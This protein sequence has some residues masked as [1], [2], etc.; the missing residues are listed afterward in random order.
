MTADAAREAGTEAKNGTEGT[1]PRPRGPESFSLAGRTA[2]VTGG[3]GG[4]GQVLVLELAAA[5]AD[6]V[7]LE[8]PR[9]PGL[10]ALDA[11]VR[12][13]GRRLHWVS[14]DLAEPEA[15][16]PVVER[17]WELTGGVD[18]LVNNAGVSSLAWLVDVDLA[19]WRRTMAVNLDAPFVLSRAVA[20]RMMRAGRPGRIVMISSKN[21]QVAESGLCAYNSSKAALEM[22]AKSMAVELGPAGITV[23]AVCPG[24]IDTDM[25]APFDLDWPAFRA[26][27]TEHIPLRGGFGAAIDVAGAVVF[28]A[29]AAGRYVTGQ[30]IVVDGGVLAQQVP[31]AR[32]MRP[33]RVPE[34]T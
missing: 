33:M 15:L 25:S 2:L 31:R 5:G 27:Y 22:L 17:V 9:H 18:V 4:I 10:P 21:G 13:L 12:A 20:V 34:A 23:N 3:G 26:Y 1:E 28:L 8:H 11:A 24:M 19:E 14:A 16:E 6:V 29:S 7:V 32:F 30:S